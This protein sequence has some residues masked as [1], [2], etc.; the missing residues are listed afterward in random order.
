MKE[1]LE[2]F[3]AWVKSETGVPVLYDPQPLRSAEPHIRLTFTGAAGEGK[4]HA[5]L[6]F[7][8]SIVGAGDGPE[9]FLDRIMEA[10]LA[11]VDFYNPCIH[12]RQVDIVLPNGSGSFRVGF[13]DVMNSSGQ[14]T[15][16]SGDE[17]ETVKWAYTYVEPHMVEFTFNRALM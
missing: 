17:G 5:T 2:E 1:I 10:S 16:N 9:V 4:T 15:R 7:Q 6:F 8:L 12:H 11:V 3:A 13:P 14:F